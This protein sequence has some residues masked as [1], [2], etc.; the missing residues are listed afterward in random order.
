MNETA[1]SIYNGQTTKSIKGRKTKLLA[2]AP[3]PALARSNFLKGAGA[4]FVR[5]PWPEH[6]AHGPTRPLARKCCKK[7]QKLGGG[8]ALWAKTI[9][10]STATPPNT[11]HSQA[12]HYTSET[13]WVERFLCFRKLETATK[14]TDR[15]SAASKCDCAF[16]RTC[17]SATRQRRNKIARAAPA[18]V[19][20][21]PPRQAPTG[22]RR[23]ILRRLHSA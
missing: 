3:F 20:T 13:W 21:S 22:A 1:Q 17:H 5:G 4:W 6:A 15:G 19:T 10:K 16:P 18:R 7:H 12:K 23:L 2:P 11:T 9:R 8:G 14:A